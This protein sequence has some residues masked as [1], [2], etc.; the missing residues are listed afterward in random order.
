MSSLR[1]KGKRFCCC[2]NT[3]SFQDKEEP[4]IYGYYTGSY[5]TLSLFTPQM[6]SLNLGGSSNNFIKNMQ[7]KISNG[8]YRKILD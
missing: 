6:I 8:L 3:G 1:R 7:I 5:S 4:N 2:F